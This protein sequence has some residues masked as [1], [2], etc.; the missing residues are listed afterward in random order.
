MI[1][2]MLSILQMAKI[3]LADIDPGSGTM[4]QWIIAGVIGS[5]IFFRRPITKALLR[6][7]DKKGTKNTDSSEEL[8]T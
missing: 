1:H 8:E 7:I 5:L 2:T 4:M 6:I 3:P